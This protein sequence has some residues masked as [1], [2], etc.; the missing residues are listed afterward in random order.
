MTHLKEKE[1]IGVLAGK[2]VTDIKITLTAGRAHLKHTEGG[3]FRQAVYRA[4]RNGLRKADSVLLEPMYAFK[5]QVPAENVGKALS[6]I[7]RM[8]GSSQLPQ[9]TASGMNLLEGEG[10]VSLFAD[11]QREVAAYTSG[12]G[13]VALSFAGYGECHNSS[14]IINAAGYNPEGDL[15]NPTGSIF[16]SH[17]SAVYVE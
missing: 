9:I 2:P 4:V 3:D 6:D 5:I 8:G 7:Q 14:E 1:H 12:R 11:Y 10:P 17:G 13:K 16:C 15:E